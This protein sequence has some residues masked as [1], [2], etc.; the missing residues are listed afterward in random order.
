MKILKNKIFLSI[1]FAVILLVFGVTFLTISGFTNK[2]E[3]NLISENTS[4]IKY[5]NAELEIAHLN[6]NAGPGEIRPSE[7]FE[8][9]SNNLD[10]YSEKENTNVKGNSEDRAILQSSTEAGDANLNNYEQQILEWINSIRTEN[11]LNALAP[12]QILTDIARSRSSD[13]LNRNYF[14]HYN[15]EGQ[16]IFDILKANGINYANAGEN[17]AHSKPAAA[18]TPEVFINAWMNSPTHKANILRGVYNKI[19]IGVIENDG[20]KVLTTAFLN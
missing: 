16:N 5:E 3:N 11:G 8:D 13:M 1:F 15:P 20:R 7:L 2:V 14:S 6:Y 12:S 9:I 10:N 19:G 4:I 17:L 18:G